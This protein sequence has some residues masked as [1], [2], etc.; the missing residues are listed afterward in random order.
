LNFLS[1][2]KRKVEDLKRRQ[3]KKMEQTLLFEIKS[4]QAEAQHLANLEEQNARAE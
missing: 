2:E 4:Q 1:Q 3:K